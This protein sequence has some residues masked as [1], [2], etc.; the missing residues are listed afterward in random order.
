MGYQT[1]EAMVVRKGF[2]VE[3]LRACLDEYADLS[4]LQVGHGILFVESMFWPTCPRSLLVCIPCVT[5][6]LHPRNA[7]DLTSP[8]ASCTV[9]DLI[10]KLASPWPCFKQARRLA[11]KLL[12]VMMTCHAPLIEPF[13]CPPHWRSP[14]F[15]QVNADRTQIDF[16]V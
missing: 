3:Q 1:A 15:E 10:L 5:A 7:L 14:S 2:S 4:V 12:G 9:L 11:P 13:F 8:L 6:C 16:V